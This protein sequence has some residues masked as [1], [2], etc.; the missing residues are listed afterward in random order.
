M[1]YPSIF[2]IKLSSYFIMTSRLSDHSNGKAIL[3]HLHI[4]DDSAE[5]F[6]DL[7]EYPC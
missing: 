5:I 4:L 1:I 2:N 3:Y 7:S 6:E